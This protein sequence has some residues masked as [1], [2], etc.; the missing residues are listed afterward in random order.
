MSTI[1]AAYSR[2]SQAKLALV[3][4]K[5]RSATAI[6]PN[7][8]SGLF[9]ATFL[10][11]LQALILGLRIADGFGQHLVQFSLGFCRFPLG[12]LPFGHELYVGIPDAELNP[13]GPVCMSASVR[14]TDS[15]RTSRHVC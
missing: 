14:I 13:A 1:G 9:A 8:S 3:T 4:D 10:D 5:I 6:K 15:S 12:W 7:A 11:P 2:V